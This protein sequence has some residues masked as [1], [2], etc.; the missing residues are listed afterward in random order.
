MAIPDVLLSG[1]HA[2][3]AKWRRAQAERLTEGAA[4]RSLGRAPGPVGGA[5]GLMTLGTSLVHAHRRARP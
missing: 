5:E 2:E 1:N 4:S 3:I